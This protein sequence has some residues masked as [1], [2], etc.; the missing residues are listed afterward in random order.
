[1]SATRCHISCKVCNTQTADSQRWVGDAVF[2][3]YAFTSTQRP[4]LTDQRTSESELHTACDLH[5]FRTPFSFK[6]LACLTLKSWFK[7]LAN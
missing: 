4:V 7:R 2:N 5:C 6:G 1:M 3:I